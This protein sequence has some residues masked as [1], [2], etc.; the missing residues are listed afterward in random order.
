MKSHPVAAQFFHVDGQTDRQTK[1]TNLTVA[2]GNF[3]KAPKIMNSDWHQILFPESSVTHETYT[4]LNRQSTERLMVSKDIPPRWKESEHGRCYQPDR[5][6]NA[7]VLSVFLLLYVQCNLHKCWSTKD[8]GFFLRPLPA[9]KPFPNSPRHKTVRLSSQ[10]C[11][12]MQKQVTP[13]EQ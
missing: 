8:G 5:T 4:S 12:D 2:F 1:V 11:Y 9:A 3:A 7:V 10:L 6:E 13:F